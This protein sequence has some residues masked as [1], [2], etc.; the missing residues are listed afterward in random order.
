MYVFEHVPGFDEY[1]IIHRCP[2]GG[3]K[4]KYSAIQTEDEIPVEV[5]IS[6]ASHTRDPLKEIQIIKL[7]VD[8]NMITGMDDDG[9]CVVRK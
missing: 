6:G 3:G 7:R 9:D 2:E 5:R 8:D 4:Y 1:R